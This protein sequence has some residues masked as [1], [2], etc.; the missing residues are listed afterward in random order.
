METFLKCGGGG[1]RQNRAF[2]GGD[3]NCM[4]TVPKIR[5]C[6]GDNPLYSV[7]VPNIFG[8]H[9]LTFPDIFGNATEY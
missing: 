8:R 2:P 6:R 9:I 1:G 7:W 5:E 4:N 3:M